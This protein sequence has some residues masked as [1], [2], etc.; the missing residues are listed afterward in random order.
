M[1]N[2]CIICEEQGNNHFCSICVYGNPCLGCDDYD[3]ETDSCKSNGGCGRK[4]D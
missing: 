3:S 1:D 4:E 2:V